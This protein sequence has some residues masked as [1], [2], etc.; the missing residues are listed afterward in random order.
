MR[1]HLLEQKL[2]DAIKRHQVVRLQYKNQL[3]SRTFCPYVIYKSAKDKILVAGWQMVDDSKPA[4][5][6]EWHNFEVEL[7][8]AFGV[9]DKTFRFDDLFDPTNKAY[10]NGII[11]II[12]RLKVE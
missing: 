10:D 11:C 3:Y 1:N 2:C 4:K 9:T 5:A 12:K 8:S 6:P 7:I